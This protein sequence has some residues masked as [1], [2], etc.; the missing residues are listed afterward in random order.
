M[1]RLDAP[2]ELA[3]LDA[4]RMRHF[5]HQLP[6]AAEAAFERGRAVPLPIERPESILICGMGGSA[7][8]GDLIRTQLLSI[9]DCPIVVHRGDKLPAFA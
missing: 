5:L 2:E 4:G 3:R 6:E 1:Q 9:C 8:S 7:I